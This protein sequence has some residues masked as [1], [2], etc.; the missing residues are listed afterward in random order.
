[1]ATYFVRA[2]ASGGNDGTQATADKGWASAQLL[3]AGTSTPAARPG[4][5]MPRAGRGE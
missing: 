3:T 1:M 5:R 2:D 4:E